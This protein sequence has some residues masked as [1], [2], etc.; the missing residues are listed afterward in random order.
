[1][2][3]TKQLKNNYKK[4]LRNSAH[5]GK[6]QIIENTGALAKYHKVAYNFIKKG[7]NKTT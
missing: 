6:K 5:S 2:E 3:P 7:K 1:M 4:I